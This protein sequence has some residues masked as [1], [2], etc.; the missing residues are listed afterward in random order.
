MRHS[1]KSQYTEIDER[2]IYILV[3]PI[4]NTFYLTHCNKKIL[5]NL[6]R[7]HLCGYYYKT[8]NWINEMKK[9]DLHPCLYVLDEVTCTK[10]EAFNYVIV[11]T[12]IFLD[13]GYISVSQGN[14]MAYKD[15]LLDKNVPLY[16]ER[17]NYNIKQ[18]VQCKNCKVQN[19]NRVKC[20]MFQ[21]EDND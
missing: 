16:N 18:I 19:Y 1:K 3:S 14:A 12:K 13:A 21:G 9:Q 20:K 11:W 2:V 10:V 15:N 4:S 5:K 17:R 6:Y 8:K 7:Q